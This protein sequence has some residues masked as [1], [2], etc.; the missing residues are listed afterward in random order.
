MTTLYF[1]IIVIDN[2]LLAIGGS[3]HKVLFKIGIPNGKALKK[4]REWVH[5]FKNLQSSH[6]FFKVAAKIISYTYLCFHYIR[7]AINIEHLT[8]VISKHIFFQIQQTTC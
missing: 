7:T 4:Q 8:V 6:V 3:R 2:I 1:L 5:L